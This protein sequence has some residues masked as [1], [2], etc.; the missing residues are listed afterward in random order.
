MRTD[1]KL[2]DGEEQI[3]K[4]LKV[5]AEKQAV[6]KPLHSPGIAWQRILKVAATIVIVLGV[7][8]GIV[9]LTTFRN[10]VQ[11]AGNL[12]EKS[13]RA[14]TSLKSVYMV[15]AVRTSMNEN[16]ESIDPTAGFIEF[17]VWK[18]FGKESKWRFDKPGRCIIMDGQSQYQLNK[19]GGYILKGSPK[20]GFVGWMR[21]F[22][23]PAKI[24]E[25]EMSFAKDHPSSCLVKE[26]GD[27][28][29]LTVKAKALGNYSNPYALNATIPEANTRRVYCFDKESH[30]LKALNVYVETG[31][32]NI[33]VLKLISI[34]A[35]PI[36]PDSL[37]IFSNHGGSPV[38]TLEE[39][40]S[41]TARGLKGIGSEEAVR[42]FFTACEKSDWG[43]VQRFS[44]LF[45]ISGSN[46]LKNIQ[47]RYEGSRLIYIGN[48]FTSGIYA[49][50]YVP[51]LLQLKSGDTI[52]GNMAIRNDNPY[53][54]WNIDGGY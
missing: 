16:F 49:G 41:A 45:S 25:S 42:I 3:N 54:T 6:I 13:I 22:L 23:E 24:L 31:K 44:P 27:Q 14:M 8:A 51:Y 40:D 48:S 32:E 50:E 46:T 11:A 43:T 17:K 15:F 29:E 18:E 12:L 52:E 21:L 1:L 10:P 47:R 34:T 19:S 33:C 38:L 35:D 9:Y 4:I 2:S 5:I 53:H 26:T 30:L 28:L 39:W 37:F 7:A 36:L 20:A